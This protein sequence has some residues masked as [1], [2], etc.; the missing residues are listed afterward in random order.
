M[1]NI[2]TNMSGNLRNR[3]SNWISALSSAFRTFTIN[4]T[5]YSVFLQLHLDVAHDLQLHGCIRSSG[6]ILK[7]FDGI[8]KLSTFS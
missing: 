8:N 2:P 4:A 5:G 1:T 6:H 7:N 3:L